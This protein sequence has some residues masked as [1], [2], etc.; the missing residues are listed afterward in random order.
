MND[1]QR[2]FSL[3]ATSDI[4]STVYGKKSSSWICCAWKAHTFPII[5][6]LRSR[7]RKKQQQYKH[8]Q[9]CQVICIPQ[10]RLRVY[11]TVDW[12]HCPSLVVA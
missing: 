5:T 3:R 11:R 7:L 6:N 12:H 2:Q 8:G 1:A 4:F 9:Q 10:F